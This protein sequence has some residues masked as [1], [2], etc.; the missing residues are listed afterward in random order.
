MEPKRA[1]DRSDLQRMDDLW[2]RSMWFR[3]PV[4]RPV[5]GDL[6]VL[7]GLTLG[8][9]YVINKVVPSFLYVPVNV[10]AA[11]A[12]VFAAR[13]TGTTLAD[14]GMRWDRL[15]RGALVGLAAAVPV[16]LVVAIGAV[17]P[18]TRHYF[19]DQRVL[20]ISTRAMVYEAL[21]RIPIGTAVCEEVI[22]RG[23]LLG[24][25][26]RRRTPLSA[27]LISSILFGLWH[28][29][30]TLDTLKLNPVGTLVHGSW[31][32][33]A[34]AV[35]AA[36]LATAAAG[37]GL[38]WLRLRANS[39]VAPIICHIALDVGPFVAGRLIMSSDS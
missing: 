35:F 31:I 29:I 22:F 32:R 13:T 25:L 19:A 5:R 28:I 2:R 33:T 26:L 7:V 16:I 10:A 34:D 24:I 36:V 37:V 17:L 3:T 23:A 20:G 1:D 30:P 27:V 15:A 18:A 14:M 8:Y 12:V 39:V 4:S 21:I 9:S 6:L 11:L 38:A